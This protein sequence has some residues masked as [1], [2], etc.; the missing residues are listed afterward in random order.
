VELA[1][2]T[3]DEAEGVDVKAVLSGGPAAE[4]GLKAGDRILTID[5]R[6]TDTIGDAYVAASFAKPGKPVAVVVKRDGKEVKLTVSPK[7]GL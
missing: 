3:D 1:K 6:W 5:G 7:P 2:D 4:G